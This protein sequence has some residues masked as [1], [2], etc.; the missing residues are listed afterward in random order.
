[1]AGRV[2]RRVMPLPS[3]EAGNNARLQ[4]SN[5]CT[6]VERRN[7][8][9]APHEREKA[10]Y[11]W[12]RRRIFRSPGEIGQLQRMRVDRR[13]PQLCKVQRAARMIH[14][15]VREKNGFRARARAIQRF[16]GVSNL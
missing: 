2:P 8:D 14:V 9:E 3:G 1:M 7:V 10:A 12:I 4:G 5:A 13:V 15:A 16:S 6:E 11:G